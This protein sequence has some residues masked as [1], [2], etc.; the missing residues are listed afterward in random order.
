[1]SAHTAELV[2]PMCFLCHEGNKGGI[3][4]PAGLEGEEA[5]FDGIVL[6]DRPLPV[7]KARKMED[8]HM[9]EAHSQKE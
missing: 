3:L 5:R 8:D 9:L 7:D 6:S 4:W 1:M 2:V